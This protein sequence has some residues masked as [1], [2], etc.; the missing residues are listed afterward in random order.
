M[1]GTLHEDRYM[2]LIISRSILPRVRNF[3]EKKSC[4]ENQN[5][6]FVFSNFFFPES[7]TVYEIMCK[8]IAQPSRPQMTI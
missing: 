1:T 2:F 4:T 7:C 6:H 3:S 5:T 8:N